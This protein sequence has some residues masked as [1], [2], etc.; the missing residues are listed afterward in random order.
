MPRNV[1]A[2]RLHFPFFNKKNYFSCA[3]P[4]LGRPIYL[5]FDAPTEDCFVFRDFPAG[6]IQ[7]CIKQKMETHWLPI[8]SLAL[9]LRHCFPICIH[10]SAPYQVP[11]KTTLCT[12][13]PYRVRYMLGLGRNTYDSF[14]LAVS[15]CV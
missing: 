10:S 7:I 4:W 9:S 8:N 13:L 14:L 12:N 3:F 6:E 5:N 2:S 11:T 1:S 15:L